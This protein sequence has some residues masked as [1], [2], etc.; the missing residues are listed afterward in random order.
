MCTT[1]HASSSIRCVPIHV[2]FNVILSP[3]WDMAQ[4]KQ[5]KGREAS[6]G[7][8]NMSRRTTP[9][10]RHCPLATRTKLAACESLEWSVPGTWRNEVILKLRPRA[11]AVS[12]DTQSRV[13]GMESRWRIGRTRPQTMAL[14]LVNDA[15]PASAAASSSI[16]RPALRRDPRCAC[17]DYRVSG[18]TSEQ[19]A[20]RRNSDS[21]TVFLWKMTVTEFRSVTRVI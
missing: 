20:S 12:T 15:R 21:R 11:V 8:T 4:D 13:F 17:R 14:P 10:S 9:T 18:A 6:S 19:V 2:H 1:V 3:W 7:I 16:V 5:A